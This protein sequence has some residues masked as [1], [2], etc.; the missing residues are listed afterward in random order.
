MYGNTKLY[1]SDPLKT[2]LIR[3]AV[4]DRTFYI[5]NVTNL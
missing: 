5:T 3:L 4:S 1:I 2:F